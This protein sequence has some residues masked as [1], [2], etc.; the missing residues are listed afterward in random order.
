M[1]ERPAMQI[2]RMLLEFQFFYAYVFG[3]LS[4]KRYKDLQ[5]QQMIKELD[6][7]LAEF[8]ETAIFIRLKHHFILLV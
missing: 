1:E 6:E 4:G 5:C 2:R 7:K 8:E 3:N